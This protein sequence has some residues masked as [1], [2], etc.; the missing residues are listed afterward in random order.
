MSNEAGFPQIGSPFVN[1]GGRIN[2]AWLQLLIALW[3]RTGGGMGMDPG[4]LDQ[5]N[6]WA[7]TATGGVNSIILGVAGFAGYSDGQRIAFRGAGKNTGPVV[8]VVSGFSALPVKKANDQL[9]TGSEV[10]PGR[11]YELLVNGNMGQFELSEFMPQS[12]NEIL[13]QLLTVDGP[14]SGLDADTV[15]GLHFIDIQSQDVLASQVFGS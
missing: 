15:D 9:L 4:T 1:E 14:G 12:P 5:R 11:Y 10:L 13:L 2:Q 8:A 7:G 6:F 3:N